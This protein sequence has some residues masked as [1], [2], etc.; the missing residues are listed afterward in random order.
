MWI[1]TG[2]ARHELNSEDP[3]W[4]RCLRCEARAIQNDRNVLCILLLWM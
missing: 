3:I 2:H 1:S 4:L